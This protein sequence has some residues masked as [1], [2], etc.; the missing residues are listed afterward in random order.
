VG[1]GKCTGKPIILDPIPGTKETGMMYEQS[2]LDIEY[3]TDVLRK[4]LTPETA[5]AFIQHEHNV[6]FF[7]GQTFSYWWDAKGDLWVRRP[8]QKPDG[9]FNHEDLCLF[10]YTKP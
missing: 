8:F 5:T 9:F 3:T 7:Q 2:R 6:F 1:F 10:E 4:I